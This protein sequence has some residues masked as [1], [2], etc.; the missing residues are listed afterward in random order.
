V[1]GFGYDTLN[2]TIP[3]EEASRPM[4]HGERALVKK[5]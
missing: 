1:S 4:D 3:G 5:G 2:P